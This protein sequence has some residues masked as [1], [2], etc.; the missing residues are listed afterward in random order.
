MTQIDKIIRHDISHDKHYLEKL[1]SDNGINKARLLGISVNGFIENI[2]E[3][4]YMY[5]FNMII[6]F[7]I[8]YFISFK[9]IT[10]LTL[11][12]LQF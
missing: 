3:G 7:Q 11:S 2:K 5:T 8:T 4:K 12:T 10:L 6:C 9:F 1:A